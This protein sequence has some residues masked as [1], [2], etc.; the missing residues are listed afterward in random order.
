MFYVYIKS[1]K[2]CFT[3]LRLLN[4]ILFEFLLRDSCMLTV[5]VLQLAFDEHD[6]R[7]LVLEVLKAETTFTSRTNSAADGSK[8]RRLLTCPRSPL[9][10]S[11]LDPPNHPNAVS[12]PT[13]LD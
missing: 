6:E 12:S 3:D 7:C 5:T 8:Q 9:F 13:T 2:I 10:F 1:F 4:F 11:T